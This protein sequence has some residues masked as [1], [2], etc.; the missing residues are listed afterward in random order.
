MLLSTGGIRSAWNHDGAAYL[1]GP[2]IN[3]QNPEDSCGINIFAFEACS[4]KYLGGTTLE[5]YNNVRKAIDV[6]GNV[7]VGVG[8]DGGGAVLKWTGGLAYKCVVDEVHLFE[9][10]E[11]GKQMDGL[12]AELCFHQG[13]I[14]VTTWPKLNLVDPAKSMEAGVWMSP[15]LDPCLGLEAEDAQPHK[16]EKVWS[17]LDY[18]PDR[19]T[20][21]SYGGGAIEN[22][23]GYVYWGTMHVPLMAALTHFQIFG[24]LENPLELAATLLGTWRAISSCI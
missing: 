13:R 24:E 18:E 19:V 23:G 6:N 17:V 10:E 14:Y 11:V 21:L 2:A 15:E 22:Y 4:G 3:P 16:W 20:A 7:Y 8:G 12:V 9:F 1:A 5:K